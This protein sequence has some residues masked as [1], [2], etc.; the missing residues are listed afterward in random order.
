MHRSGTS[1]IAR[2][3]RVLGVELGDN[4]MPAIANNNDKG[5]WEDVD[6]TML[7]VE[8]LSLIGSD[9][10][11]LTPIQS[12]DIEI[13]RKKKY[14]LH[15]AE[16]LRRKMGDAPIFGFKDPRVAKLLPFWKEV[17]SCCQLDV[18]YVMSLRHPLSVVKSLT[19]RDGIDAEKSYLLWLGHIITSLTGCA[20]ATRVLVDYDRLMQSPDRELMRIAK[21]TGLQIDPT[22]LQSYKS[23]FLDQ[24]L[25]HTV[26][27]VN[28]LLL[29]AACPPLAHEMYAVLLDVGS[30]KTQIDDLKLQKKIKHWATEFERLKTTLRLA[31]RLYTRNIAAT[32]A[33][34][35]RDEQIISLNQSVTMRDSEI[36]RLIQAL[37]DRDGQITDLNQIAVNRDRQISG[38][39]QAVGDRDGQIVSLHRRLTDTEASLV[40]QTHKLTVEHFTEIAATKER[41]AKIQTAL[42]ETQKMAIDYANEIK[43]LNERLA[44]I[45]QT[46][47]E[48]QKMVWIRA[49]EIKQLVKRLDAREEEIKRLEKNLIAL[50]K[51]FFWRITAPLRWLSRRLLKR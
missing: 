29:D 16:L 34:G 13:L 40:E 5:F 47:Q 4:L 15:A 24:E 49:A 7:N 38:L 43:Q 19:K 2:G 23:E 32:Q 42:E 44:I 27:D 51:R 46:H 26:F 39:S 18:N 33:I 48:A 11:C 31:D 36:S 50:Q 45:D 37:A 22:E 17:F 12:G 6:L 25:R 3:L 35:A 28:D 14:F 1:A 8:I 9:W 41:L 10:H 21:C 20:D 30:D